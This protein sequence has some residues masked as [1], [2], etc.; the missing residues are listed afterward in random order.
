MDRNF[1][2]PH[3]ILNTL[4][5]V[6]DAYIVLSLLIDC[7]TTH[8]SY[9]ALVTA[10]VTQVTTSSLIDLQACLI[11]DSQHRLL[12]Y[13]S[14]SIHHFV[15][16]YSCSVQHL[17]HFDD[18]TFAI[19][20]LSLSVHLRKHSEHSVNFPVT[21]PVKLQLPHEKHSTRNSHIS[22]QKNSTRNGS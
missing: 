21:L 2:V 19:L 7:V 11:N 15:K 13:D 18:W 20:S 16:Y 14:S 3:S 1:V 17:A 22:I 9:S 12:D 10:S 4:R 5:G 6:L 8:R